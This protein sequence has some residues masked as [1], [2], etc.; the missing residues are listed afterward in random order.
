M[1]YFWLIIILLIIFLYIY[2]RFFYFFRDPE[3][4]IPSGSNV[5]APADGTVV[6]VKEF[7]KNEIPISI[8]RNRS[9]DIR[10][11]VK[12]EIVSNYD[13]FIIGIFMH[14][15]SVHINRSPIDGVAEKIEYFKGRNLPMTLMWWRV[16]LGIRPFERGS[17]HITSNERNIISIKGSIQA[18]VIQIADI[19][20][21]KIECYISPGSALVKGQK[22]GAI[23]MGSQVDLILPKISN[24][25][26]KVKE[27]DKVYAGSSILATY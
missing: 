21:N 10:D 2:W 12:S 14:P 3:R 26:I 22:I 1:I 18:I 6:Y 16:L 27:S 8:K 25:L 13:F 9:V 7:K 23:K 11:L 5:V 4:K 19:Y 20:V 17:N 24:L 15:T